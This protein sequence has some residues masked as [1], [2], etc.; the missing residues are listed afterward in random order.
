[1]NQVIYIYICAC[2]YYISTF[3]HNIVNVCIICIY[4]CGATGYSLWLQNRGD[5][6]TRQ[7]KKKEVEDRAAAI[8]FEVAAAEDNTDRKQCMFEP[9]L[10]FFNCVLTYLCVS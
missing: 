7:K 9:Y 6:Q 3:V 2:G 10:L 1:M 5:V 4:W 8:R